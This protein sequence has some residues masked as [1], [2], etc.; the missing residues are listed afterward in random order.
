MTRRPGWVIR[1]AQER[2][3]ILLQRAEDV[4]YSDREKAKRYVELS[5]KIAM[6]Y[7]IRMSRKW[8][9]RICKGCHAFL[10]PG[11][12][13]RIRTKD[14]KLIITCLECGHITRIPFLKERKQKRKRLMK[15]KDDKG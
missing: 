3:D 8:K 5:R 7:N 15:L 2:I 11:E 10:K 9:R 12:N 4:F 13:C 14:A 1:I 6:R